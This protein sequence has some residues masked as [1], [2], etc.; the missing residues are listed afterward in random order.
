[1]KQKFALD[2]FMPSLCSCNIAIYI[3]H[4][5]GIDSYVYACTGTSL[6]GLNNSGYLL[7]VCKNWPSRDK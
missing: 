5:Y 2:S 4:W 7:L 1:M 6:V 3:V